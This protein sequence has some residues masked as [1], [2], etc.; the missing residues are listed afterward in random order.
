[1]SL[2]SSRN[3]VKSTKCSSSKV[4]KMSLI[5]RI[6]LSNSRTNSIYFSHSFRTI[7]WETTSTSYSRSG[8]TPFRMRV[9][10]SKTTRFNLGPHFLDRATT[11]RGLV[12]SK[13]PSGEGF[14]FSRVSQRGH[15]MSSLRKSTVFSR[16]IRRW[17]Q[18]FRFRTFPK[19]RAPWKR[20]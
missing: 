20:R 2:K 6:N 7:Y 17:S 8:T 9:S 10:L 5:S 3:L 13:R 14:S 1:M 12:I 18:C 16:Q 19:D 11:C 4:K 15:S